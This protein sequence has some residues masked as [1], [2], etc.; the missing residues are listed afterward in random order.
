MRR[1]FIGPDAAAPA[2]PRLRITGEPYMGR[3][4]AANSIGSW[5]VGL[6]DRAGEC[7]LSATGEDDREDARVDASSMG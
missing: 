1:T 3:G 5:W 7:N 6:T 4:N 2:N